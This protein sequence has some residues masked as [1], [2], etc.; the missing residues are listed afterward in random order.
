MTG[1]QTGRR[2]GGR[3]WPARRPGLLAA[4]LVASATPLLAQQ[5]SVDRRIRENQQQLD[6]IRQERTQLQ[7]EL[8][9]LRT[10]AHTLEGE[11][12]NLER[13]RSAT[14]RIVNE[15][16]RQMRSLAEQLDTVTMDLVL[17]QDALAEKRAVLQ[18]RVVQIYK[19][20][21]LWT[22]QVLL[23]AASFG[24]LLSRY[25]YL[26]LVSRQD[27]ALVGEVEELHERIS[28]QRRDLIAIRN[29]LSRRRDERGSELDRYLSLERQ[30]QRSLQQARSSTQRTVT[31]LD[32]LRR[33]EENLADIIA[34]LE[35]ERRRAVASGA[36]LGPGSIAADDLGTLD[37]PVDGELA[38][39]FGRARGPDD[40]SIRYQGIG[41]R[42]AVGTP[43][44]VVADGVVDLARALDTWGPT[45]IVR[46]G[47]GFYTVYAYLSRL[48]VI[49][50]QRVV[51]G[52][53]LGL[54]GGQGSDAGPHIEF[55]IRQGRSD[56]P[57]IPLDPLNWL[58]RQ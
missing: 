9:R 54:S 45:I 19:R 56:A 17:A 18:K 53:R 50:G 2:T 34:T 46:H 24:E 55:Q 49:R 12:Q 26:Y 22:F 31:R 16:D 14:S 13:Q 41:I 15:L 3:K 32:S 8:E 57:P 27:R 6:S 52:E 4:L 47:G 48:D 33:A 38:Y 10:R 1:G 21:S 29:E 25:K 39:R 30:R 37:W 23:S 51:R 7:R 35:R 58:K 28:A 42:T 43:V 40:T 44:R 20:G 36:E 11:L 5:G